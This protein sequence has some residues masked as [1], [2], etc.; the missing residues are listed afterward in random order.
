[1][2]VVIGRQSSKSDDV[3]PHA[4]VIDLKSLSLKVI[5]R[6]TAEIGWS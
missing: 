1:M 6:L 4:L 5:E 2:H 3:E